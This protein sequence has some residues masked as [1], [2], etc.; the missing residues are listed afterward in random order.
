M[1]AQNQKEA[2]I[3]SVLLNVA[4][5]LAIMA[6]PL[7]MLRGLQMRREKKIGLATVFLR[8]SSSYLSFLTV[9]SDDLT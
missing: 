4:S 6:L 2:L 1:G 8:K 5:D 3:M 9:L 7:S